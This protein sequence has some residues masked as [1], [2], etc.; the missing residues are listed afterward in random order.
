MGTVAKAGLVRQG[1]GGSL[2]PGYLSAELPAQQLTSRE[3][4]RLLPRTTLGVCGSV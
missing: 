2:E 1:S 3:Q 4:P